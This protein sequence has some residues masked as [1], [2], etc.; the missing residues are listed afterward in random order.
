[1]CPTSPTAEEMQPRV[2]PNVRTPRIRMLIQ[3]QMEPTRLLALLSRPLRP[4]TP[5]PR[6][7]YSWLSCLRVELRSS[8]GALIVRITYCNYSGAMLIETPIPKSINDA[9][10]RIQLDDLFCRKKKYF[11]HKV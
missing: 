8:S 11:D 6:A 2:A 4:H 3:A 7:L 10:I 9:D 1:M 5:L